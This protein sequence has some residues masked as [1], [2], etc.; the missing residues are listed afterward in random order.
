LENNAS[1]DT[2]KIILKKQPEA[3]QQQNKDGYLPLHMSFSHGTSENI[4]ALLL[5]VYPEAAA[6]KC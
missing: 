3:S 5:E 2:V 4:I 6:W 1:Y